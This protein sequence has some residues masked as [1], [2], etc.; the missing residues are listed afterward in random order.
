MNLAKKILSVFLL[1]FYLA[2]SV[3]AGTQTQHAP[4]LEQ[5][6]ADGNL[7]KPTSTTD[8]V[9]GPVLYIDLLTQATEMDQCASAYPDDKQAASWSLIADIHN[10]AAQNRLS[11]FLVRHRLE[12]KF[13]KE[14]AA[15]LR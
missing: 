10:S 5:C 14:D 6:R 9:N 7:W 3:G 4:T 8:V 2:A 12:N 11:N 1:G 15:G 13:L